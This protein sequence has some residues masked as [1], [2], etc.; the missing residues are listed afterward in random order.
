MKNKQLL[1]QAMRMH[2]DKYNTVMYE[3]AI[4]YLTTILDGDTW[5]FDKLTKTKMFWEWWKRQWERRENSFSQIHQLYKIDAKDY[6]EVSE[7]IHELWLEVH[8]IE[9]LNIYPNNVVME[10]TY[11]E[12]IGEAIGGDERKK[13]GTA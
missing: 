6:N 12:M 8:S 3:T 9:S 5:A 4:Q 10:A 7:I 2:E 1:L 11:R 13:G